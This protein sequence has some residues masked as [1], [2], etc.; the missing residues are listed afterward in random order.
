MK[1]DLEIS[2]ETCTTAIESWIAG[3]PTI[4]LIFF[5]NP[6]FF[7]PEHATASTLCEKVEQLPEMIDQLLNNG[8]SAKVIKTRNKH[9]E[10]W[11]D[12]P[13]GDSCLRLASLIARSVRS[14]PEPDWTQ[15]KFTDYRRAAKLKFLRQLGVAY[16][17][18]PLMPFKMLM[19][20]ESYLI[21]KQ[22]YEKSIKPGDAKVMRDRLAY[23][24]KVEER[25]HNPGTN[26]TLLG[27]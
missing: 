19:N 2:C 22:A 27:E 20:R 7:H 16:H 11:C 14:L 21:K 6:M 23:A 15:L 8:E 10:K 5:K 1:C 9:L 17:F 18:D 4:E 13:K 12:T 25:N 3:K 26:V 24:L